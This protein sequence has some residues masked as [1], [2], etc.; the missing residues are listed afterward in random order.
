MMSKSHKISTS[1]RDSKSHYGFE[2]KRPLEII[3]GLI[4]S[5]N[6]TRNLTRDL[7]RNL[8]LS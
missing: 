1:L 4:R 8:K 6:P 3:K 5:R 2:T 7:T